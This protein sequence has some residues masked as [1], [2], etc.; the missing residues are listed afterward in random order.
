MFFNFG[1]ELI[2]NAIAKSSEQAHMGYSGARV[3]FRVDGGK[4]AIM[5]RIPPH[6][7][8]IELWWSMNPSLP[9]GARGG[10]GVMVGFGGVIYPANAPLGDDLGRLKERD[11]RVLLMV[12][13]YRHLQRQVSA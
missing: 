6:T 1:L 8:T 10:G 5:K 4:P 11:R 7:S 2:R 12:G 3:K 9:L 13:R